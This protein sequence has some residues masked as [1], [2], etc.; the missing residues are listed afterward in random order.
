MKLCTTKGSQSIYVLL[1]IYAA[2]TTTTTLPCLAIILN[3]PI[4][5]SETI[6]QGINSVS[7][8][9]KLLLL[10]SYIPFFLIPLVMTLDMATRVLKIVNANAGMGA[11]S[12][13][14]KL[15]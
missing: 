1:L 3:T 7:F 8:Q 12:T 10:S 6:V 13:K 14:R 2:S 5:S 15:K 11:E 9:Q 4:T